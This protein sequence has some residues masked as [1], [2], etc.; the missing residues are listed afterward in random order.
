MAKVETVKIETEN[1]E[2]L[3]NKSDFDEK[4]H[5]L[6]GQEKK[7]VRRTRKTKA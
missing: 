1:G 6:A 7:P 4:K 2:V 5:T 3:I